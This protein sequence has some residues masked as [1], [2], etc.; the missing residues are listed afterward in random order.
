MFQFHMKMDEEVLDVLMLEMTHGIVVINMILLLALQDGHVMRPQE[1]VLWPI[2]VMDSEVNQ[3][4][5]ITANHIQ[6]QAHM[7]ETL[8]DATSHHSSV[9]NVRKVILVAAQIEEPNAQTA[10]PQLI[11]FSDAT[12]QMLN[13]QNVKNAQRVTQLDV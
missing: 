4:A 12:E 6:V 3:L 1:N 8:I 10:K 2:Q 13:N 9:K 7:V 5:K 11:C